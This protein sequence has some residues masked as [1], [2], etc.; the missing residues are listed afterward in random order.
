M[1]KLNGKTYAYTKKG[2]EKYKKALAKKKKVTTDY[3]YPP[4]KTKK[5]CR[6]RW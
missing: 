5:I 3:D 4:S 6:N 2:K 1:P